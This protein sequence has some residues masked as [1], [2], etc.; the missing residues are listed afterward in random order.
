MDGCTA[1]EMVSVG[2]S[3]SC[4]VTMN[5]FTSSSLINM[6]INWKVDTFS[7]RQHITTGITSPV[8]NSAELGLV[9]LDGEWLLVMTPKVLSKRENEEKEREFVSLHLR[10]DTNKGEDVPARFWLR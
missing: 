5:A 3:L 4:A 6:V 10:R 2:D 7:F 9:G 8:I 1:K